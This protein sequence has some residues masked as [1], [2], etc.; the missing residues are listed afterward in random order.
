MHTPPST[1][2]AV[3]G[4]PQMAG[5]S[6]LPLAQQ[7]LSAMTAAPLGI[8]WLSFPRF[9]I[10]R[11]SLTRGL[12]RFLPFSRSYQGTPIPRESWSSHPGKKVTLARKAQNISGI[13]NILKP[14]LLLDI[15][16]ILHL[17]VRRP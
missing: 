3:R 14:E 4:A 8:S 6:A 10:F 5:L 15:H 12:S 9:S 1:R 17:A 13:H 2:S 7:L 16:Y 11:K